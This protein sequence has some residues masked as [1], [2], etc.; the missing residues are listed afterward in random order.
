MA[1]G[2]TIRKKTYKGD[3][4]IE[5]SEEKLDTINL[6]SSSSSSSF[7]AGEGKGVCNMLE[8][9]QKLCCT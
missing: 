5:T 6:I 3:V 4:E 9:T 8:C 2:A 7:S 1:V